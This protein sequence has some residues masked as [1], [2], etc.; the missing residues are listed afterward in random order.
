MQEK[1]STMQEKI[2]NLL[3][4]AIESA[5]NIAIDNRNKLTAFERLLQKRNSSLFQ[6]YLEILK[7]VRNNLPTSVLPESFQGLRSKLALP[8]SS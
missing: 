4:D 6:E 3:V 1:E 8:E 5:T 7:K 2:A